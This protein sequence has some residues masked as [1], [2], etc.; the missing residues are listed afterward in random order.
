M[1]SNEPGTPPAASARRR[2]HVVT[3]IILV[4]LL[5]VFRGAIRAWFSGKPAAGASASVTS[6]GGPSAP[7]QRDEIAYY[8]CSMHPA[9]R[10]HGPGKC[11]ICDMD[12][13][14]V[15][16][17]ETASG[18]VVLDDG[19]RQ[20]IGI[21]TGLVERRRAAESIHA[22]GKVAFDESRLA[23]VTVKVQGFAGRL[24]VS[25]VGQR[26]ARGQVLCMLYSPEIYLAEREYLAALASQREARR[27][28]VPD[29]ADD[30]LAAAA[31]KL[32]LWDVDEGVITRLNERGEPDKEIP[33]RSPASGVVIAKDVVQGAAVQPGMKLYRIAGLD[34]VWVDAQVYQA[35]LPRV[36][37]GQQATV[38]LSALP[39]RELSGRVALI[40]PTLDPASRTAQVRIALPGPV[41]G[42]PALLP[43][44]VAE[45]E[46]GAAQ[47][48]V[49]VVPDGAVLYTGP[50]T[51]V[52]V[53]EGGGR[54]RSREVRL[55]ARSGDV[56]TVLSGLAA[57]ERVV[58]SGQF[59]LDAEGRLKRP[60][61]GPDR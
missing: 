12:L 14:P 1:S 52:F 51:L 40:F 59:L 8:T 58:T 9:V 50:R 35:D 11:P 47:G 55:G 30:L 39:G 33:V 43:D 38:R 44:M 53:D 19:R 60:A 15:R 29:R 46:L 57:G 22:V 7:G 24:L 56:Y 41:H 10:Q 61:A 32:R 37:A 17:A 23:D 16:R 27:T 3:A 20:E 13:I 45:V 34:R 25:Q 36:R 49:L 18:V 54:F 4:A 28:A 21:R 26:V 48:E 5:L 2:V 6:P 42:S 31:Q